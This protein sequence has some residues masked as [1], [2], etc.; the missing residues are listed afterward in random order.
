MRTI[1]RQSSAVTLRATVPLFRQSRDRR[2]TNQLSTSL[3]LSS[4][5]ETQSDLEV[6]ASLTGGLQCWHS[7]LFIRDGGYLFCLFITNFSVVNVIERSLGTA[8]SEDLKLR[9]CSFCFL[10]QFSIQQNT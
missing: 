7:R 3:C 4:H 2:R 10:G 8:S 6:E 5:I 9:C 1:H